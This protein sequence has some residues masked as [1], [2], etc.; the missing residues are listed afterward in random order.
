[1]RKTFATLLLA[2]PLMAAVPARALDQGAFNAVA[3]EIPVPQPKKYD[4]RAVLAGL[5]ARPDVAAEFDADAKVALTDPQLKALMVAKWRGKA[6]AYA[7]TQVNRPGVDYS[8]TYHNWKEVLGPEGYA[9]LRQRLGSMT[10]EDVDKLVGYLG[11]LDQK[12]QANNYKI[13]DS[14]F[15]IAN[16]I[17]AGILDE[18]RKDLGQYLAAP[19]TR[20]A[21]TALAS[22]SSQ[23]AAGIQAKNALAAAPAKPVPPTAPAETVPAKPKPVK[24][25]PKQPVAK[26][27]K[28][29]KPETPVQ[30]EVPPSHVGGPVVGAPPADSA[31]GQLGNAERGGQNA[32][33]V[34]D[35]GFS[36]GQP[37]AVVPGGST[38]SRPVPPAPIPGGLAPSAPSGSAPVVGSVPSPLDDLDA[39]VAKAGKDGVKPY[40]GKV[41]MA[42]GGGGALIGGLIGFLL[43]GPIGLAIGAAVGAGGGYLLSKRF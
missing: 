22:N 1:M 13:D 41:G 29:A 10:K 11:M 24:P 16:K 40:A 7:T 2:L 4:E 36:G 6:A 25:D 21:Q 12:L 19:E 14:M 9:Y 33:N 31:R 37:P 5:L 26:P 15:S 43:G 34:F 23:L 38:D 35:G 3:A 28:P 32:G 27:S 8:K 18:Y 17:A 42:F 20:S 30:P 39:R